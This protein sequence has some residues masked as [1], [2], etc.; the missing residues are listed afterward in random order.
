MYPPVHS[1]LVAA[2]L[3]QSYVGQRVY[4]H[5]L[6]P[7]KVP[8]P[9]VT[10]Y[11]AGGAPENQLDGVPLIDS[12]VVTVRVW[13]DANA[14]ADPFAIGEA[15]RDALEPHAFMEDVPSSGR[16]TETKRYWL[17]MT[18]RFWTDREPI[19]SSTSI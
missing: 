2:Q 15:V 19:E 11:V 10:W 1:I 18:F 6:A 13:A 3:V 12:Y 17:A 14:G 9:Y 16:D 7:D 8:T 4:P 5:G